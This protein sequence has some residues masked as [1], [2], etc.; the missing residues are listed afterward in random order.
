MVRKSWDVVVVGAGTVGVSVGYELSR[1]GLSVAILERAE[2]ASGCSY[3]NAGLLAPSHVET[4]ATP[5][6]V[7]AGLQY[8]WSPS[9]PFHVRP[10]L[11][12]AKWLASFAASSRPGRARVATGKLQALAS[13][14]LAIHRKY[15][16]SGLTTGL[17]NAGSLDVFLS[18]PKFQRARQR[19]EADGSGR[20]LTRREV[21]EVEPTVAGVVGGILHPEDAHCDSYR[22][23]RALAKAARSQGAEVRTHTVVTG[24]DVA[25][26]QIRGVVT[27]NE[28]VSAGM[29]VVAAGVGSSGLCQSV[30]VRLPMQAGRG[31]ILDFGW[32]G[33]RRPRLPVTFKEPRVVAT[34]Y[35]NR[36]RLSGTLELGS[37]TGAMSQRR[38]NAIVKAGGLCLPSVRL[39]Q[40]IS[41]RIGDRPCLVDGIPAIGPSMR[42]DKLLVA[43]GHGMWGLILAPITGEL[44]ADYVLDRKFSDGMSLFSPDRFTQ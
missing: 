25:H 31:Y 28:T 4:L 21:E 36:L 37:R 22:F 44:I 34:P 40:V 12:I 41:K 26:G 27:P 7:M 6:N 16:D 3:A 43:T 2:V 30:G 39:G 42:R 11:G 29:Y 35:P 15:A 18:E 8:M 1:R 14:S 17:N 5:A 10:S 19:A 33:Q 20:I 9:S 38:V 24:F 23:V 13:A 32:S